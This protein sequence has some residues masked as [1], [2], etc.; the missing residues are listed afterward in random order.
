MAFEYQALEPNQIRLLRVNPTV[1]NALGYVECT[2]VQASLANPPPY[3]ALSYTWGNQIRYRNVLI[4]G[5]R[6]PVTPNLESFLRQVLSSLQEGKEVGYLWI[7]AICVDQSNIDE[8]GHQVGCMRRIFEQSHG[9]IVWLG[10]LTEVIRRFFERVR[11][12]KQ[13]SHTSRTIQPP[14]EFLTHSFWTRIWVLQEITTP[15][16]KGQVHI[17]YGNQSVEFDA[18]MDA[19]IDRVDGSSTPTRTKEVFGA[20]LDV[21]NRRRF[22]EDIPVD[23]LLGQLQRWKASDGR[24]LLYAPL[25]LSAKVPEF[26]PDYS[27]TEAETYID[28]AMCRIRATGRLDLLAYAASPRKG[29]P[30]WTPD[31]SVK[32]HKQ[33]MD[34]FYNLDFCSLA[35]DCGLRGGSEVLCPRDFPRGFPAI[36]VAGFC[37]GR[38][39]SGAAADFNTG[40]LT[41]LLRPRTASHDIQSNSPWIT[42]L[43]ESFANRGSELIF[44]KQRRSSARKLSLKP[45]L[46]SNNLE[47]YEMERVGALWAGA[48]SPICPRYIITPASATVGD[49][50]CVL[51]GAST[52]VILREVDVGNGIKTYIYV[53]QCI[54]HHLIKGMGTLDAV[55]AILQRELSIGPAIERS[56]RS[57]ISDAL[58]NEAQKMELEVKKELYDLTHGY[59]PMYG[60]EWHGEHLKVRLELLGIDLLRYTTSFVLI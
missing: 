45:W 10:D 16:E 12:Q 32:H 26:E 54:A 49:C 35:A 18:V 23:D 50:L 53:G 52:P 56:E 59:I 27:L 15:L 14:T 30:S 60:S 47:G 36:R 57:V 55:C 42:S 39:K 19:I 25:Q 13:T 3:T 31:W 21:R 34:K 1:S 22:H 6:L 17:W 29:L 41:E 4:D 9:L 5:C 37:V 46:E 44:P 38:L 33:R 24:D 2:L 51:L 58:R 40:Q 48:Y 11:S 7:D 20:I 8:R 43:P 28:F